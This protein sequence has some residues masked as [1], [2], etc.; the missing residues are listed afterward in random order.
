MLTLIGV[1]PT[2]KMNKLWDKLLGLRLGGNYEHD[3]LTS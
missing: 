2:G 3:W 1:Y